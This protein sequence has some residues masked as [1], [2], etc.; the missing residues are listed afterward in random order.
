MNNNVSNVD[1]IFESAVAR[2][3]H[4][5][6]VGRSCVLMQVPMPEVITEGVS[7][8]ATVAKAAQKTKE[9][10]ID[11]TTLDE[12]ILVKL[13]ECAHE[14]NELWEKLMSPWPCYG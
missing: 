13:R 12:D 1:E 8:F 9:S 2:L 7:I 5:A 4:L 14:A 10:V 11:G 3:E 6:L